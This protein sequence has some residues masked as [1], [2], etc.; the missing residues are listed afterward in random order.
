[1]TS[2]HTHL[3]VLAQLYP[4]L[5][6][7]AVQ[8]PAGD[9]EL[10]GGLLDGHPAPDGLQRR[11]KVVLGSESYVRGTRWTVTRLTWLHV[12]ATALNG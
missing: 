12:V 6:A 7:A 2:C 11:V 1:M 8:R 9:P 4:D 10:G 5:L 3:G